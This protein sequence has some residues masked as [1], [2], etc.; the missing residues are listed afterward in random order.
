MASWLRLFLLNN[1]VRSFAFSFAFLS[2]VD[3]FAEETEK[4]A[5]LKIE[6]EQLIQPEITR[7]E[8]ELDKID[9]EDFEAT[10]FT[11]FLNVED[12]GTNVV[13]GAR[14]AY[15]INEDV[16][17]EATLAQSTA[18]QTSFERLSG[19]TPLLTADQRQITYYDISLG[20]NLLPGESFLTRNT[21]FN[22][23]IYL[24]AGLGNT[25]FA[26]SDKLTINIG[27]GFRLLATDWLA[28]HID[29]RDHIFNIDILAEDKT[30]NNLEV[31]FGIS[32]FF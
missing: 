25:T 24:I 3:S 20:Y 5:P 27:G 11:G 30:A 31:T 21:S 7:R 13:V 28:L 6:S 16:F 12:F 10:I 18:G 22:S 9:T 8:V 29:V 26:G 17:I 4:A 15:H 1:I 19:G 2:T 32:A 23:A 14:F